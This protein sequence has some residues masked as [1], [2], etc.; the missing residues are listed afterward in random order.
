LGLIYS[1]ATSCLLG[2]AVFLQQINHV[3]DLAPALYFVCWQEVEI[4][5][6]CREE[7]RQ[8]LADASNQASYVLLIVCMIYLIISLVIYLLRLSL[9]V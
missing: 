1:D 5:K 6:R 2:I 4:F 3:Y 9:L 8:L 7:M